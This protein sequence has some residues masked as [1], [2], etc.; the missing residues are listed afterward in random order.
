MTDI[1]S[2]AKRSEVMAAVRG[3]GNSSTEMRVMALFREYGVTGWRRHQPLLGC[4]DFV[5]RKEKVVVFVDGCFWHGYPRCYKAP[6]TRKEFWAK[7]L[8]ENRRRDRRVSRQL[9]A[10]G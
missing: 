3:K 9:R 2:K 1:W 7:K 6:A 5:F 4:P 8:E 10:D